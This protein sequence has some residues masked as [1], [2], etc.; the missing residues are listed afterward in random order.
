MVSTQHY[1]DL[2]IAGIRASR[3]AQGLSTGDIDRQETFF[4]LNY[5]IQVAPYARLTPNIQYVL[6]PDQLRYPDRPKPIPDALVIGAKL[7]IDLF[8]LAGLAKGPEDRL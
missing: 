7:S 6:D 5:G 1:S 3:I 4:E 2:G 8:T